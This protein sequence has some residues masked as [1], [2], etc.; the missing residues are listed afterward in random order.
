LP[1]LHQAA[2]T[3]PPAKKSAAKRSR[4]RSKAKSKNAAPPPPAPKASAPAQSSGGGG[5]LADTGAD[6]KVLILQANNA[7]TQR[8][9]KRA[10]DLYTQAARLD[11]K[12]RRIGVMAYTGLMKV[13]EKTG[14]PQS[15]L[16]QQPRME[17]AKITTPG[18]AEGLWVAARIR[19][20]LGQQA[21][22]KRLYEKLLKSGKYK[23]KAQARLDAMSKQ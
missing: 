18:A 17:R 7:F 10:Q 22:A 16:Q 20:E 5:G 1:V 19:M 8:D 4:K 11:P 6:A 3:P 2:R 9:Y 13:Y 23:A 15:A 21:Q 12:G 14:R